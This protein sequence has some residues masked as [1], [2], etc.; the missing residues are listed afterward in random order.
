M[1]YTPVG[2][3]AVQR[4]L[5]QHWSAHIVGSYDAKRYLGRLHQ[6]LS[7]GVLPAVFGSYSRVRCDWSA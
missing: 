6:V 7:D 3:N 2:P 1:A 5:G 4:A